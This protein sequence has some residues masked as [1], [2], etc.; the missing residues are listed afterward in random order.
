MLDVLGVYFL[1][2]D[3]SLLV[4]NVC[5]IQRVHA[6]LLFFFAYFLPHSS[7]KQA[8]E[9]EKAAKIAAEEARNSQKFDKP[10]ILA[11][12]SNKD[13]KFLRMKDGRG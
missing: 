13:K 2:G 9:A 7:T 3:I 4:L 1:F 8:I 10:T 6:E 12:L 11:Y 5:L